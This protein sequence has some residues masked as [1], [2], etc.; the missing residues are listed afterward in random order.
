MLGP[1]F[2]GGQAGD[3]H[4]DGAVVQLGDQVAELHIF[5]DQFFA[6]V[7]GDPLGQLDV[8]PHDGVFAVYDLVEFV[9]GVICR[10]AQHQR[11]FFRLAVIAA[12]APRAARLFCTARQGHG[13]HSR[14]QQGG[15]LF[16]LFHIQ[17]LHRCVFIHCM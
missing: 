12:R 3:D 9:G 11:V 4:I 17:F 1:L 6:H 2:I 13:H 14:Q 16:H 5:N 10:G 7:I 15:Q 8:G